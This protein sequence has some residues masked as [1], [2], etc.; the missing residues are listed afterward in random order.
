MAIPPSGTFNYVAVVPQDIRDGAVECAVQSMPSAG[1]DTTRLVGRA[2]TLRV[3]AAGLT[4]DAGPARPWVMR[5]RLTLEASGR[6]GATVAAVS[7]HVDQAI[8]GRLEP[9]DVIHL[10]RTMCGG[11]GLSVIRHGE[12]VVAVGA[13][14]SVPLGGAVA[15]R[16]PGALISE[17]QALFRRR[18]PLFEFREL[19][20]EIS[21]NDQVSLLF[22]GRRTMEPYSSHVLHGHLIGLPGQNE[23]VSICRTGACP[24]DAATASAM[25]LDDPA[26][27]TR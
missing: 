14:T 8:M 17:A 23:C 24:E 7:F 16:I 13:V 26:A 2:P 9:G 1:A 10:A 18:D 12:L 20:V 15:A 25:L 4:P 6:R 22:G 21:V 5:S 27:L 11:L 3:T 19:P